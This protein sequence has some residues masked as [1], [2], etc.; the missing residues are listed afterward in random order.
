MS[1]EGQSIRVLHVD[2]DEQLCDLATLHLERANDAFE[3]VTETSA[4]DGLDR[5]DHDPIDCVVSDHDMPGM[6]GLEFLRAVRDRDEEL[7]FILY[8]GKGSEEIASDAISAGVTDYLQKGTTSDQ[9]DLLANR[10]ERGVAEVRAR[11]AHEESERTFATLVANLPGMVYRCRNE[12]G[13]PMEFV[14]E[15]ARELTGYDATAIETGDVDWE[16]DVI[17]DS[18]REEV[19]EQ[20][21]LALDAGEPFEVTYRIRTA[22]DERRWV[23]ERGRTVEVDDDV[24]VI[25]G[26]ITD[27]TARKE[28]ERELESERAFSANVID[29][30][31]D[32]F[33]I[34]RTDGRFVR[35]NDRFNEVT[36]YTDAEIA[37]LVVTDLFPETEYDT[38]FESVNEAM[39]H[40]STSF[41]APILT[42]DGTQ[43]PYEFRGTAFEE[44]EGGQPAIVGIGRDISDRVRR[45]RELERYETVIQA[46][47]DP[48]YTL[49]ADGYFTFVNGALAGLT[50]YDAG[51]LLGKHIELVIDEDDLET[52][53][54]KIITMLGADDKRY[55]I[56]EMDVVT[57][58]SDRIPCENHIALLPMPDGE[59]RGTA[60]VIRDITE[61]KERERRLEEFASVVSHD[62]RNP[63]EVLSGRVELARETGDV[64]HLDAVER[65][66]DRMHQ[67]IEDLLRLAHRGEGVDE[68]EGVDL[69]SAAEQA[70]QS[71][72]TAESSL[73]VD[74]TAA[75]EADPGRLQALFENLFRN[76]IEHGSEDA[77]ADTALTVA[78]GTTDDGFYVADDGVGIPDEQRPE[79]FD[80]GY[81][82][83]PDG[84]G[85]GLAIVADV[86]DAH[87]WAVTVTESEDGGARFEFDV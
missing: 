12:R 26:F 50:G 57:K 63:L 65:P 4:S 20:V 24:D 28:R 56:F 61:R 11:A 76:A 85:Y 78:V 40:E 3:V 51:E 74:G 22:G 17:Y 53:R 77:A 45:E 1:R 46:V 30:L 2:D 42:K 68:L 31:E 73:V 15:G 60:G 41:E 10:I 13:W 33:Y 25:E 49:D 47:G 16:D 18:D 38:L 29:A 83:Q 32:L 80:R 55:S 37:D 70:W 21:Q 36:G 66:L 79:I 43:I 59:F 67:L 34:V 82:T 19:W 72:D 52:G 64:S 7:P 58:E 69:A 87:G 27:I 44:I 54:E 71:I 9:Y 84:T 35:W 48:M 5:I 39:E 6:D 86:A 81:T 75:I 62:L 14:S 8:T 23:W